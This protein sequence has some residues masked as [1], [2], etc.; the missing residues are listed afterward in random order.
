M[1]K[2]FG[3][4]TNPLLGSPTAVEIT[5]VS[6]KMDGWIEKEEEEGVV[7]NR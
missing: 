2:F 5:F 4:A 1:L 7:L 6:A 3:F